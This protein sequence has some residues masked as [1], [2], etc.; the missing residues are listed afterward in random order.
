MRVGGLSHIS[1]LQHAANGTHHLANAIFSYVFPVSQSVSQSRSKRDPGTMAMNDS[2]LRC[3][4]DDNEHEQR[5]CCLT[6]YDSALP[7]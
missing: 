6:K 2:D 7:E 4:S 1:T 3:Y 5:W